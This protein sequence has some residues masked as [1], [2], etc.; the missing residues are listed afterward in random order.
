MAPAV[1]KATKRRPIEFEDVKVEL[2]AT[3]E[4]RPG[5]EELRPFQGKIFVRLSEEEAA[6]HDDGEVT[7]EE[8]DEGARDWREVGYVY[9]D[10]FLDVEYYPGDE[11]EGA[12]YALDPISSDHTLL[13]DLI[14]SNLE[15]LWDGSPDIVEGMV[16]FRQLRIKP[17]Y[18]GRGIGAHALTHLVKFWRRDIRPTHAFL[19]AVPQ[20]PGENGEDADDFYK[21]NPEAYR[22]QQARLFGFYTSLRFQRLGQSE[23]MVFRLGRA[24]Q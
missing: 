24:Q 2:T 19:L 23:A 4:V 7:P 3:L 9:A 6:R 22:K 18:R 8:F 5:E 21:Q 15:S 12:Y 20:D 17:E 10:E 14:Q 11:N 13:H 16:F 1:P